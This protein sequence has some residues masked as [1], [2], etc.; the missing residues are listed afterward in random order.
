MIMQ[1]KYAFVCLV[2]SS[3]M[4]SSCTPLPQ[5]GS[6]FLSPSIRHN[7]PVFPS[8][9]WVLPKAMFIITL[10]AIL[11]PPNVYCVYNVS[12]L[13]LEEEEWKFE[14]QQI[15][16]HWIIFRNFLCLV[17]LFFI[18]TQVSHVACK[19]ILKLCKPTIN[20]YNNNTLTIGV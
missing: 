14:E 15:R 1:S 13:C 8:S 5:H 16:M 11:F 9:E 7:T 12:L 20:V 18:I 19:K 17:K 2:Y 3:Q 10:L 6:I 4:F